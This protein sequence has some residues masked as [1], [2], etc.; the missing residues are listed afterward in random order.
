M[1]R[2]KVKS[3]AHSL[4]YVTLALVLDRGHLAGSR[5]TVLTPLLSS[6]ER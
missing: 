2:S 4:D 3:E 5:P 6:Q 1:R